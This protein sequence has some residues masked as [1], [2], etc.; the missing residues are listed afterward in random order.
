MEKINISLGSTDSVGTPPENNVNVLLALLT[1]FKG[2]EELS[3]NLITK[4]VLN[5]EFFIEED[6][7]NLKGHELNILNSIKE[8]NNTIFFINSKINDL[9]NLSKDKVKLT[10]EN[11]ETVRDGL[12][13]QYLQSIIMK[14][15]LTVKSFILETYEVPENKLIEEAKC[16]YNVILSCI[17]SLKISKL[18]TTDDYKIK[19]HNF[20]EAFIVNIA[21]VDDSL[22]LKEVE[23]L[24]NIFKQTN[25]ADD[26]KNKSLYQTKTEEIIDNV[27][28]L[29]KELGWYSETV[30]QWTYTGVYEMALNIIAADG[31]QDKRELDLLSKYFEKLDKEIGF[32][33]KPPNF[34]SSTTPS[35]Y[36]DG[37][38]SENKL[39]L[40]DGLLAELSKMIGL[41]SVKNEVNNLCNLVRVN[42]MR[43]QANLTT[44]N[45][46][47]HLVF[48]GNP[49][50][51]KTT[52]ARLL[53]KIFNSLGLLAKGHLVEVGR[54]DLVGG[55]I[56]QT[57][58]KTKEVIDSSLGGILFIDEAYSLARTSSNDD[59][60][61]EA[62][63]TLLKAMEDQR[64]NLVV[65]VAGYPNEMAQF[66]NSNPGLKSRFSKYVHFPD[67][68]EIEMMKIIQKIATDSS[69]NFSTK[70]EQMF[71][72]VINQLYANKTEHFGNART[73]RN[74]FEHV[75]QQHS[76]RIITIN[77]P[78]TDELQLIKEEDVSGFLQD[79]NS[80]LKRN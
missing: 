25:T 9:S 35:G 42:K 46:S 6:I 79:P 76:N 31:E 56:G 14:S 58:I 62:V 43:E 50:T 27:V 55:Y 28:L 2:I 51:G 1:E 54:S 20:I 22:S 3:L 66:I 69:Y 17:D 18:V 71:Q 77:N 72:Q 39:H 40:L 34:Q 73:V 8:T 10:V 21:V 60:G 45:M 48:T 68:D 63:E 11:Y 64:E 36:T 41:V 53:A 16:Y 12:L 75:V 59:Y 49:G 26:Y 19:A 74:L 24:N 5:P 33:T 78:G 30:S 13:E 7:R 47:L 44:T 23:L 61:R 38:S 37:E 52:V 32:K 15:A 80:T 57:A 4:M 65:I 67:F 29:I 70:A